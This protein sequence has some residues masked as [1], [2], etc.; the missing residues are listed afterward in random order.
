MK[1]DEVKERLKQSLSTTER[2]RASK[3][4]TSG[5]MITLIKQTREKQRKEMYIFL[6]IALVFIM[7]TVLFIARAPL[8]FAGF[9]VVVTVVGIGFLVVERRFQYE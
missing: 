5:E 8:L 6:I 1:E 9:Q 4:P 2:S 7:S 3:K